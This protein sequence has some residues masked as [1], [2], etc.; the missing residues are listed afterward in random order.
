MIAKL[1]AGPAKEVLKNVLKKIDDLITKHTASQIGHVI[2]WSQMTKAQ[3]KAFQNSCSRHASEL[4]LPKWSEKSAE[5]LRKQFNAIV[6][7][8]KANGTQLGYYPMKPFNGKSV[9]VRFWEWTYG[10]VK[11]YYY[12]TLD[13]IFIS[14]G[15]A[16]I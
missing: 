2:P 4:G 13:G 9:P 10:G 12:E 5:E 1:P 7:H 6:G 8:I 16:R 11:Y 15:K 14:A 3:K